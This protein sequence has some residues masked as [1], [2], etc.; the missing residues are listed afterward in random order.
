MIAGGVGGFREGLRQYQSQ[1]AAL[2]SKPKKKTSA[3]KLRCAPQTAKPKP[4]STP[5]KKPAQRR[6][7]R[8]ARSTPTAAA[9]IERGIGGLRAGLDECG[10]RKAAA[11]ASAAPDPQ[12]APQGPITLHHGTGKI[13]D[14]P[15]TQG[16]KDVLRTGLLSMTA[17]RDIADEFAGGGRDGRIYSLQVPREAVLDLRNRSAKQLPKLLEEAKRDGRYSVAAI[18]DITFGSDEPEFRLLRPPAPSA[19][20]V[21]RSDESVENY[22]AY[23]DVV[24]R[25]KSGE[26]VSQKERDEARELLKEDLEV[27]KEILEIME[28]EQGGDPAAAAL[29]SRLGEDAS[30]YR[31]LSE[32]PA[33]TPA[34]DERSLAGRVES[35]RA[36]DQPA[37]PAGE[38]S[39]QHQR[40]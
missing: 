6:P 29:R 13:F 36:R 24:R 4:K 17:N 35:L 26:P 3:R 10:R 15:P 32:A 19:W 39:A 20:R 14:G 1:T 11:A 25:L 12:P 9:L 2:A 38:L 7:A 18:D 27:N 16:G 40:R 5:R 30:V 28:E 22:A 34:T 8:N 21:E 31:A 33:P 23:D 37:Q